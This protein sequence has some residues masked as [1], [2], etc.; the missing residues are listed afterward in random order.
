MVLLERFEDASNGKD[1]VIASSSST[2]E[3]D[4]AFAMTQFPVALTAE[5]P[6]SACHA[7]VRQQLPDPSAIAGRGSP[8][9]YELHKRHLQPL[10]PRD[11]FLEEAQMSNWA[12]GI[13]STLDI[14]ARAP[15]P[16]AD[17]PVISS[18][19]TSTRPDAELYAPILKRPCFAELAEPR[20]PPTSRPLCTIAELRKRPLPTIAAAARFDERHLRHMD[21]SSACFA[22]FQQPAGCSSSPRPRVPSVI[23]SGHHDRIFG[24]S[25]REMQRNKFVE[26]HVLKLTPL[27]SGNSRPKPKEQAKTWKLEE[28][29]WKT[30]SAWSDS[31]TF[32]DTVEV[33]E[34]AFNL[35]WS[36]ALR[37]H[38][39]ANFILKH[40]DGESDDEADDDDDG[41]PD[42]EIVEVGNVL[43]RHHE[44][45]YRTFD[46]YAG[47]GSA[48]DFTRIGLG[49]FKQFCTDCKLVVAGSKFCASAHLDQLFLLI[50]TPERKA[51]DGQAAFKGVR[52]GGK[53]GTAT[54]TV[55]ADSNSRALNRQEWLQCLVRICIMRYVQPGKERDV[56]T[57][58]DRLLTNDIEPNLSGATLQDSNAFRLEQCYSEATDSILVAHSSSLRAV[59]DVYA[60][61]DGKD[62]SSAHLAKV[63]SCTEWKKMLDDLGWVDTEFTLREAMLAFVWARM[64][65]ADELAAESKAKL[66]HLSFEDFLDAFVRIATMKALP[67]DDEVHEYGCE[68]GGEF[69]LQL[70]DSPAE[71]AAW[72]RN[73]AQRWD[74]ALRQPI[75]RAVS[76]LVML[77]IRSIEKATHGIAKAK[78]DLILTKLEV[79]A[80]E[81][82]G[83]LSATG[84]QDK[85]TRRP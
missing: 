48:S 54:T 79:Q 80:F 3:P 58:M 69:L 12:A 76:Q 41:V 19:S 1:A 66:H 43:W 61:I 77:L 28:S 20:G 44:L 35:D 2:N 11:D 36:Q 31:G 56:S 81:G 6:T 82:N 47:I 55:V 50:N 68:D 34:R 32:Y 24:T 7:P 53:R 17:T 18:S 16:I 29:I 45:V 60:S 4:E 72:V 8:R 73:H 15:P 52:L 49:G 84:H 74:E 9:L 25:V 59:F 5:S 46:A 40:D 67:T 62:M 33:Y 39:L 85:G 64:R 83:G 63:L 10:A 14:W 78:Q 57:A 26:P 30:R 75:H 21:R 22:R 71:H 70:R 51:K 27:R 42:D 38:S 13:A 23:T 37:S 65:V